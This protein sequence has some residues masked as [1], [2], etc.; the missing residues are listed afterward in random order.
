MTHRILIRDCT[1]LT[2]SAA[3]LHHH[4]FVTIEGPV[5]SSL[6]PMAD[7]PDPKDFC[8]IEGQAKLVMPGLVNGHNHAAMTLFRGFADDLSLH[9]WLHDH[10][11][12]AEAAHVNPEMVYWSAKLAAAEMICS[13]TT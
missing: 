4:Y 5:V 6:G 8:L 3:P 9:S 7:C 10:I 11:F 13:G 12:P 1:L 2:D